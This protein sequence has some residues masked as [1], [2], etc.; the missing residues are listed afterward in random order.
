MNKMK[1]AMLKLLEQWI[2]SSW[3]RGY[4]KE[5]KKEKQNILIRC[6]SY[7][8]TRN[9]YQNRNIKILKVDNMNYHY[10]L[11]LIVILLI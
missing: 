1:K 2:N 5:K 4:C 9:K 8:N 11:Y 6:N 10:H 7:L 3:K